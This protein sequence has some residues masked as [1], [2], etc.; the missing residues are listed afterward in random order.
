MK[1][2]TFLVASIC[3][4]GTSRAAT[5]P[6]L[7]YSYYEGTWNFLPDFN[8]LTPVKRGT[9][10]NFDI[11]VKNRE[12]S[13]GIVWQGYVMIPVAGNYTFQTTSDDGSQL[14]INGNTTPLVDNNGVHSATSVSGTI[15]LEAGPY[16]IKVLFFQNS[17][18]GSMDVYWSSNTGLASQKIPDNALSSDITSSEGLTGTRNFYFSSVTGDDSRSEA[19]AQNTATPWKSLKKL[20]SFFP[21]LQ[22]GDAIL[23]HRGETF[24]GNI[25]IA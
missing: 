5:S 25:E 7:S 4:F 20:N 24:D 10:A 9:S 22:P 21:N 17:G 8:S 16:P 14:Y 2:F 18:S 12:L 1:L 19:Q 15:Y 13:Y 6:G 23:F 3:L 11:S